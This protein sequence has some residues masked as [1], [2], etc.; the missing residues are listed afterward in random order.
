MK[1]KQSVRTW[2]AVIVVNVVLIALLV[3]AAEFAARQMELQNASTLPPMQPDPELGWVPPPNMEGRV[4]TSEFDVTHYTNELGLSDDPV[5]DATGRQGIRILALGDSHTAATGVAPAETWPNVLER[6][7]FEERQAAGTVFNA[8]V[9]GYSLGQELVRMRQLD[10]VLD[11]DIVLIGFSTATDFYDVV[12]PS[13]GGFIY[14]AESGRVYF[15]LDESGALVERHD[16]VGQ[17][18]ATGHEERST[19]QRI[20]EVLDQ[21]ALYRLAKRSKLAMRMAV[22]LQP[23]TG[24]LWPGLDTA[25]K[26]ELSEDDAYRIALAQEIIG[27]IADEAKAEDREVVLVHIPYIAQVYDDVW[28][29]SFGMYPERYDR[30]LGTRRLRDI[31]NEEGIHLADTMDALVAETRRTGERLH[32][33]LDA[34][35]TPAGHEVIARAVAEVLVRE[36]LVPHNGFDTAQAR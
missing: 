16:L 6:L 8:G 22:W 7:L 33:E 3:A 28:Q 12:P 15:D 35:P 14:G 26:L 4:T 20:R 31:A 21:F 25:L 2:T 18:L 24:S 11:P 36:G 19:A 34:H 1:S 27:Q 29:A 13:R 9:G 23:A 10:D 32:Y 5:N 17:K 30:H